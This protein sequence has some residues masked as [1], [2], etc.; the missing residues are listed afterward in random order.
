V[1][2]PSD[3]DE[4]HTLRVETVKRED[5]AWVIVQGEADLATLQELEAGLT[6]V[7]LD[8]TKAVHLH[9]SRLTF[10]DVASLRQLTMFAR[11]AKEAGR[12]IKTCGANPTLRK[13]ARL[14]RVHEDLGLA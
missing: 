2:S 3:T 10:A 1:D 13:V 6:R 7:Q 14:L 4:A 5:V 11:S 9:L 12:D 8:G